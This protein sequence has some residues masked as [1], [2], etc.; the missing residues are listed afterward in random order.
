MEPTKPLLTVAIPTWNRASFLSKTL[1][2]LLS[3]MARIPEGMV[4][5]LVTD[6][7]SPDDTQ[8]VVQRM[9]ERGLAIT[10][11]R[12]DENIGSDANIAACFNKAA[13]KYVLILGDD[14]L[15]VDHSLA[16]V[17]DIVKAKEYGVV[18]LRPFGFEFDFRKEIPGDRQANKEYV[19][20]SDFLVKLGP[21]F[22]LISSCIINRDLISH[23][24]AND[25]CGSNLVQNELVLHAVFEAKQ[26]F[27]VG[28]YTIAC[29]RNN[30]SGYEFSTIFVKNFGAILDKYQIKGLKP[31]AIRRIENQMLLAFYPYYLTRQRIQHA[32]LNE[33]TLLNFET[34][35][36]NRCLYLLW[37]LPT[38]KLWR[39]L[40]I[41][42]GLMTIFVGRTINGDL[43]RGMYFAWNRLKR[44][45]ANAK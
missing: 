31:S 34:R 45:V 11:I 17:L 21:R 1:E 30:S 16:A 23:I 41:C 15:F 7:A 12:N 14:D 44:T 25:F 13:G 9:I 39:P 36:H 6:N 40:A 37:I 28:Q 5:V 29:F 4:E 43:I 8:R 2:Q 27:Y 20:G 38:M 32:A 33:V 42:W 26:N 22:T 35:F 10:S 19:D 18:F 3:E 24:D